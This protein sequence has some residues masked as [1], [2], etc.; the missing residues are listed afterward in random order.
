MH[1]VSPLLH[2]Y[3]V[4]QTSRQIRRSKSSIEQVVRTRIE[5][6]TAQL[7]SQDE[8]ISARTV[9]LRK[10]NDSN[11]AKKRMRVALVIMAWGGLRVQCRVG[12][13]RRNVAG[14]VAMSPLWLGFI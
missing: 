13:N 3:R 9:V 1:S 4:A 7:E 5:Y 12:E 8:G 14:N 2:V 10:K 11:D 6:S